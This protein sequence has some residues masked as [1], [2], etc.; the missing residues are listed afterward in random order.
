MSDRLNARTKNIRDSIEKITTSVDLVLG[1]FGFLKKVIML[2]RW[3][4]RNTA[5]NALKRKKVNEKSI[6]DSRL[7]SSKF[8][9]FS[10][11]FLKIFSQ[12]INL[13]PSAA[14]KSSE[15]K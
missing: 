3:K 14:K 12:I 9:L 5:K 15:L 2:V 4:S 8:G 11:A 1:C 13:L 10:S 6:G 7:R